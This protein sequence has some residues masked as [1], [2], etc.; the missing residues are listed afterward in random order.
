M[1]MRVWVC[2]VNGVLVDTIAVGRAAFAATARHFGTT[3]TAR[4]IARVDGLGLVD[5]YQVLDP[6]GDA[7][8]RRRFHLAYVRERLDDM[9]AYPGVAETLAAA[10]AEGVRIGA[11]TS[12]GETAEACLVHTGL[13]GYLDCLV[14]AEEVRR[15][16]PHPEAILRVLGLLDIDPQGA[17]ARGALGI[18]DCV[19]DIVAGRTAGIATVGVTYGA[20]DEAEIRRAGPDYV[21]QS[22]RDMRLWLAEPASTT[23]A[24][25]RRHAASH[26]ALPH[27]PL[28]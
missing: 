18:G 7:L 5:A 23:V 26:T 14:T 3:V 28:P 27:T 10:R 16:K 20:S 17:D 24:A 21:I 4:E 25:V 6:A 8:A 13:Y 11:A 1:G 12:H 9:P 15:S 2:D 19:V 22:F